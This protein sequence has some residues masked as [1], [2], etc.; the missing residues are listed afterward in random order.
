MDNKPFWSSGRPWAAQEPFK[1][2]GGKAL[3]FLEGF[4]A[5]RVRPEP[6]NDRF[7]I[8]SLNH[9]LLNP[10]ETALD[11]ASGAVF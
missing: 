2:V 9:L 1:K 11:L 3:T 7:V 6:Q 4:W 10:R 8:E 5:A